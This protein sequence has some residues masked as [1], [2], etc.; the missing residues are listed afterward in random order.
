MSDEREPWPAD[1]EPAP[2]SGRSVGGAPAFDR[3]IG[4]DGEPGPPRPRK[5]IVVLVV[6]VVLI[7]TLV[8]CCVA[9]REALSL[10]FLDV[11]AYL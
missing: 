4:E 1:D 3:S 10:I 8:L 2:A 11:P 5:G 7:G 9:A 6:A